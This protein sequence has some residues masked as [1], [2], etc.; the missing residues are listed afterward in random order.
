MTMKKT[1]FVVDDNVTN[2]T[3]AANALKSH[4]TVRTIPSGEK[5]IDLLEKIRPDIFLLDIEMPGMDGFDILRY[6]KGDERFRS[7]PVIF[8]TAKIDFDTEIEALEMGVVDFIGKPFNPAVLLNRIRHHIDINELVRERTF[9]LHKAREDI[10][11]VLA[12]IVET[13]D[14]ST[15][16]HLG[17]TSRLV[18]SLLEHLLEKKVYYDQI[19]GWDFDLM[20]ECSLMH[21]VGKISTPDAI[22][23]K[24]GK[25]T[26][27]EWVI[28]KQHTIEGEKIIRKIAN[29]SGENVF[30]RN[31]KIFAISHHERW[32][33][34]GYPYGLRG[35]DIPLQG[36]LM[37][38]ADVYDALIS[39]R[40]Y[41]DAFSPDEA[42]GIM[43][44]EKGTQFDPLLI[45][46]VC[47]ILGK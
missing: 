2:L 29:R 25:L 40:V 9:Q 45:D 31:A 34:G 47:E 6:L 13:R 28:M 5:T 1:V 14:D 41:K 32:D 30:L 8:L 43:L 22:L 4:Y 26:P 37:A 18:K 39:K 35:Y 23:K 10:I 46:M 24:P 19:S 21:D 42:L 11:F 27:E 7:L 38:I 33:G 12:D 17:R 16:D 44:N 15:G 36:R 3:M 20:A